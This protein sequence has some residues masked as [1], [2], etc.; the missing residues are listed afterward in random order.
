MPTAEAFV[1]SSTEEAEQRMRWNALLPP[2]TSEPYRTIGP[3]EFTSVVVAVLPVASELVDA[4]PHHV[5]AGTVDHTVGVRDRSNALTSPDEDAPMHQ[6]MLNKWTLN[7]RS[8]PTTAEVRFE[9]G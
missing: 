7:V 3:Q 1:F 8:P 6:Y 9:D 5:K 4:G 2:E